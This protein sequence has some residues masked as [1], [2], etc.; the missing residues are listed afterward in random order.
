M[1]IYPFQL[2][3]EEYKVKKKKKQKER[4]VLFRT[5]YMF[6]SMVEKRKE[7]KK[8]K[9]YPLEIDDINSFPPP[10]TLTHITFCHSLIVLALTFLLPL[11]Y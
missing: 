3:K 10:H 9:K 4:K 1:V 8:I 2:L 7:R 6:N 5:F 11:R